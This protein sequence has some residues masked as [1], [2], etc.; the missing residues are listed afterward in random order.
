MVLLSTWMIFGLKGDEVND[1]IDVEILINAYPLY[2]KDVLGN[3]K[4]LIMN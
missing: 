1:K 2:L 3:Q 4:V